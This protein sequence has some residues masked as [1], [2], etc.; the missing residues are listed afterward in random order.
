MTENYREV[1]EMF[2]ISKLII[3]VMHRHHLI[4]FIGLPSSVDT[5]K[6]EKCKTLKG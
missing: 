4:Y 6:R 5:L 2:Q 1:Y 3:E